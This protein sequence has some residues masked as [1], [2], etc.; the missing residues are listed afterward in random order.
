MCVPYA[1]FY[2][3]R[4]FG[5]KEHGLGTIITMVNEEFVKDNNTLIKFCVDE[6]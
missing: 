5:V 3:S 6:E 4:A 2:C 1:F